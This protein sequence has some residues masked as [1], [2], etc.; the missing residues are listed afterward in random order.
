MRTTPHGPMTDEQWRAHYPSCPACF[1]YY[2]F[3][4][5]LA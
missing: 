1:S 5:G 4:R 3:L 2:R